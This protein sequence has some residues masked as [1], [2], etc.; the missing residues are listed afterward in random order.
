MP[1][2]MFTVLFSVL[3]TAWS[4]THA[5]GVDPGKGSAVRGRFGQ[6]GTTVVTEMSMAASVASMIMNSLPRNWDV[7]TLTTSWFLYP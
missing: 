3:Y 2:P 4:R 7:M 1:N 5:D 6:L